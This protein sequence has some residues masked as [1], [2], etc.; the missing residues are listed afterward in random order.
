MELILL[1]WLFVDRYLQNNQLKDLP[2][3]IFRYITRLRDLWVNIF[4]SWFVFTVTYPPSTNHGSLKLT[5]YAA[6]LSLRKR[7][8]MNE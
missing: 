6:A 5:L 3:D 8:Y 1:V 2:E 7:E 4:I